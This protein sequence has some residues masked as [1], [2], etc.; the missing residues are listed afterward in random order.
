MRQACWLDTG[1]DF[2]LFV[3]QMLSLRQRHRAFKKILWPFGARIFGFWHC[4][5]RSGTSY[6]WET[7]LQ[8]LGSQTEPKR[9]QNPKRPLSLLFSEWLQNFFNRSSCWWFAVFA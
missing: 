8:G 2:L 1:F 3:G 6:I 4:L 9:S 7:D 5:P